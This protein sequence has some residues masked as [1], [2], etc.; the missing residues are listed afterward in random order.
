MSERIG[1]K[2]RQNEKGLKYCNK[3]GNLLRRPEVNLYRKAGR[4]PYLIAYILNDWVA[5]GGGMK[6]WV[7]NM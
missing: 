6:T 1:L 2:F 4:I 3:T 5:S 7:H